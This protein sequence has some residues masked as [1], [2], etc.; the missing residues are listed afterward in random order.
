ML[1]TNVPMTKIGR[2]TQTGILFFPPM[3]FD[4]RAGIYVAARKAG[5]TQVATVD[6]RV[7]W[8]VLFSTWEIIV[9]GQ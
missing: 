5:I 8:Y 6:Y 2:T 4:N 9:T 7:S 3:V 1:I